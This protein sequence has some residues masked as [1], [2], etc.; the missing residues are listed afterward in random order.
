[1]TATHDAETVA[2]TGSAV[3]E[4]NW[5]R[6]RYGWDDPRVA[7]FADAV[8]AVNAV[9][10]RSPGFLWMMPEDAM[11]AAQCD[12]NGVFA[13]DPG[14]ADNR[15]A[16]TL[17]VWETTEDLARFTWRT[18]HGAFAARGGEWFEELPKPTIVLW[19]VPRDHRPSIEEA[20][21]RLTRLAREGPSDQAF[22]L[23]RPNAG[24]AAP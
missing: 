17:S 8:E 3:A 15:I 2:M 10:A 16:S 18:V 4:F 20:M 11:D 7:P 1:M 12:P 22:G 24:D 21:A 14:F 5:G 13:G 9:A 19:P 6:L 23:P